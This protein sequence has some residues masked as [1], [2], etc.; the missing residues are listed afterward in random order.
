MSSWG[1]LLGM[2]KCE[3]ECHRVVELIG[4]ADL[5]AWKI[6]PVMPTVLRAVASTYS[7]NPQ[8]A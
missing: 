8:Y 7:G 4:D 3:S 1:V 2:M 6:L 5:P